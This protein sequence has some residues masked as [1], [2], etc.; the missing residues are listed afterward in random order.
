M[1]L[2]ELLSRCAPGIVSPEQDVLV[3]TTTT[4]ARQKELIMRWSL[5]L[6]TL[7]ILPGCASGMLAESGPKFGSFATRHEVVD[8]LGA[9]RVTGRTESGT[10][11]DF[12]VRNFSRAGAANLSFIGMLTFGVVDVVMLPLVVHDTVK[13]HDVKFLYDD[14]DTVV[15]YEVDGSSDEFK[16][17]VHRATYGSGF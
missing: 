1:W 9:P 10:F 8:T 12:H 3:D 15:S 14:A 11:D 13:L 6:L 2:D 4:N 5:P 17:D 16:Q 7:L